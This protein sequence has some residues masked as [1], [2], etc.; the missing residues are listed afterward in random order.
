[1]KQSTGEDK[2][3]Q[4]VKASTSFL[5]HKH[6]CENDVE[7]IIKLFDNKLSWIGAAEH[8]YD[9]GTEKISGI[10]RQFAGMVPNCNIR[11]EEYHVINISPNVYICTGRAWIATDP[12]TGIYLRVHQRI[13]AVFRWADGTP[14][15]CHIHISNPYSKMTQEDVGFPTQMGRYTNE[16]LHQCI[17]E[18]KKKIKEQTEILKRLSFEDSLTG[19]FNRNKFNQT[20]QSFAAASFSQLGLASIDLNGLKKIND[21]MGHSAGDSLICCTAKH[22]ACVF[23]GKS[24]RIGGDE[25]LVIDTESD[26]SSFRKAVSIMRANMAQDGISVSV[27]ISWRCTHCNI[28]EQFEEADGLMYQAKAEFYSSYDNDRRRNQ[29]KSAERR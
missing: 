27:G 23:P 20:M 29:S 11:D 18:Y 24:Y 5:L 25:F 12:S 16:Y 2:R 19:L 9:V 8:E 17:D 10:F 13:T 1:M 6:Y 21:Q 14:R 26:E 15:C 7:S 4:A 22:I 3:I 28:K